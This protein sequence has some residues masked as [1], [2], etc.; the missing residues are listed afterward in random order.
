MSSTKN[1]GRLCGVVPRLRAGLP[2]NPATISSPVT[3]IVLS[4]LSLLGPGAATQADEPRAATAEQI[5][6]FESKIRP[7]FAKHCY[8]CHGEAA[9]EGKLRLDTKNGWERGGERGPTI[10]PGDPSSSLLMRAVSYRDD[11]LKMPPPDTGDKLNDAEIE[12]LRSWIR[13]GAHDP[14]SGT[15]VVTDLEKA[16]REHWAF[17]PIVAPHVA[18]NSHPIDFLIERKHRE[19]NI[20]ATEPADARTLVRRMS[21]DLLGLP[22]SAEEIS[23][24]EKEFA[25]ESLRNSASSQ[26]VTRPQNETHPPP[27]SPQTIKRLI[28]RLLQ[29]PHYGERWGRHWL[30][31]ARYSDAKDGVLMY[32]DGRIRPF[33]YTYRDYVIR[34][35]ND[36]KPFDQFVREQLAADQLNLPADSP[37][38]AAMGLLT[39]GRMFDSNRHDV[40]DDQ[41]DVI[42]RG[43][44]GLSVACARCHDHKFDPVP[45]AD[46]YSLY[47]V[48]ASCI[49]PYDRPRIGPVT[50][51][52]Q[53]FEQEFAAKLKEIEGQQANHYTET[54]KIARERTPDYLIHVATTQPDV[55][56]TAIF[57]LSLTP[58]QL[59]PQITKRWRQLIARRAFTDDPIFGPWSDLQHDLAL[60][61]EA[62][63]ARGIDSRII[64]G[65]VA[66]QPTSMADVARIY[67]N[68]IRD[69]W[70]TGGGGES[71][72]L[73]ALLV[74]RDG[75]VWFPIRDVAF[76]LSRQPG[77]AYRGLLGQLDAI[78]VKHKD[79][80][81][82]A[83]TVHDAEVLC[84]P[85]IYQRGDPSARGTP[86]PRR[87]LEILSPENRPAFSQGGGR[88]ELANAIASPANPLTARVWVNR[89]WMHHFGDSLLENPSDFGLQAKRPVQH[90]LLD[91]LA[92]YFIKHGW[93]TKP[94]HELILSS[95]AYQRSSQ[96]PET[97]AMAQ[98]RQ[99]DPSN[100][101][102]WR[103]NRRRLDFEQMRDT[104]LTVAGEL[105]ATMFGRPAVVTDDANRRRTVYAFVERQNIPAMVQT[106]DFAN[107]DT[108][109]PRR[110]M[111]TVPQQALFALNS[112]FMLA[113]SDALAKRVADTEPARRVPR[114]YAVA[115]GREP[116]PAEV[117][118]CESFLAAGTLEQL[119]QVLLMSNELMFVD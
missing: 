1:D 28:D 78:A 85:V 99:R 83:M 45:T 21:F 17:Q 91:F 89:V 108:S 118:L 37:D 33:A 26:G 4:V 39:L 71:D 47:G 63:K 32:G 105:D 14:R 6:F 42:G 10:V 25:A 2:G 95:R 103:S 114:L 79:A 5:S 38:F 75:P 40:I 36:D 107:A 94:L 90:D 65:L 100:S 84:D 19:Q 29:S 97:E 86:V 52:G 119:A 22:P 3:V 9:A 34:A 59:R 30:D 116:T 113:R 13:N 44:L 62:W 73:V 50:E 11:K 57:F 7:L 66:A 81:S 111:T 70:T 98:Q 55:S 8:E 109:T 77:D 76:Y 20:V 49:E 93:R 27:S 61:P 48:F 92:D 23:E 101:L 67:G 46:Y 68:V 117:E 15:K 87:F 56:E 35:F 110:S 102:L 106:F 104:M 31:V 41:I 64:D 16:A 80:A 112:T 96:F 18:D 82:R 88:L 58:E 12:D 60:K 72:P 54:L 24:F 74:A 51:A 43:F 69:A 53:A 115:L